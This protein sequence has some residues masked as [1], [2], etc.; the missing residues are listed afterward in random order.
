MVTYSINI[1]LTL[2]IIRIFCRAPC[3]LVG[4]FTNWFKSWLSIISSSLLDAWDRLPGLDEFTQTLSGALKSHYFYA[5]HLPGQTFF[6]NL[7]YPLSIHM[8]P[9]TIQYNTIKYSFNSCKINT[10]TCCDN[11]K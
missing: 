2:Q 10:F 8:H 7:I 11:E 5:K 1:T 4:S 3:R 9:Y 6:L